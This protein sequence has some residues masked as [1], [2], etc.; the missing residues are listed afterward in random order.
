MNIRKTPR[1]DLENK[2]R[3]FLETGLIIALVA[4]WMAFEWKSVRTTFEVYRPDF[5]IEQVDEIPVTESKPPPL[6][7]P[8]TLSSVIEVVE[9]TAEVEEVT[10][11][12]EGES[13]VP[14]FI[15]EYYV[16]PEVD[17]NRIFIAVE[18]DPSFP[19][20]Q[21]ELMKYLSST[22]R[23]PT[24]AREAGLDGIVFISF[25][26]EK[27]G[28]ISDIRVLRGPG[29]GLDD[30]AVRVIRNMPRWKPGKQMNQPVRVQFSI[31]VR[32]VLDKR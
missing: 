14:E 32:F 5:V 17:E 7:T 3:I 19:G 11:S 10:I 24:A 15:F 31:P 27:D 1:A 13:R 16:E 4:V 23:Y 8:P 30:E 2:K 26:V 20:G 6:Q 9:D 25:V 12:S 28:S 22:L 18:E 29:G 21:V